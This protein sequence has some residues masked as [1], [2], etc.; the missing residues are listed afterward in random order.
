MGRFHGWQLNRLRRKLN[1]SDRIKRVKAA[2]KLLRMGDRSG[3]AILIEALDH[4]DTCGFAALVFADLGVRGIMPKICKMLQ[5]TKRAIVAEGLVY[6]LGKFR[7]P[8]AVTALVSLLARNSSEFEKFETAG[9]TLPPFRTFDSTGEYVRAQAA[10]V[11]G[12]IG[13]QSAI[14][15]LEQALKDP[16]YLV[17]DAA[18]L[19]LKRRR[20][21]S[22]D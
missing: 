4:E 21:V 9:P 14:G 8:D 15:A 10:R 11:L 7:G 18:A 19:A 20:V 6:P 3:Y 12:E 5:A 22:G 2:E 16:D 1:A 17:R 13:D